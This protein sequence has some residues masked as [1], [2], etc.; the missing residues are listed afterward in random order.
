MAF[1][2]PSSAVAGVQFLNQLLRNEDCRLV[3][4][5]FG[6]PQRGFTWLAI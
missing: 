5:L 1:V 2:L 3:W 4:G 6:R